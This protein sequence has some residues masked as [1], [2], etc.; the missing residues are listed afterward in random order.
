M[1]GG[2]LTGIVTT[3]DYEYSEDFCRYVL[4][5]VAIGLNEMHQKNILHRNIKS[6]NI[7][8]CSDGQIKIADSGFSV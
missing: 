5:M 6:D 1:D 2:S 3:R 4:Y 7:L 8:C